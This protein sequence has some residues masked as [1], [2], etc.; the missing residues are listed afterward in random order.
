MALSRRDLLAMAALA[1]A[2]PAL[3]VHAQQPTIKIGVL[4]DPVRAVSRSNRNDQRRLRAAGGTGFRTEGV[5]RRATPRRW[6]W[7]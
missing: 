6:R 7:P 2:A 5:Y 4:N 1:A 3:P